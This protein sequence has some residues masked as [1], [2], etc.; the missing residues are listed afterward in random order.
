MFKNLQTPWSHGGDYDNGPI[1]HEESLTSVLPESSDRSDLTL[2]IADCAETMRKAILD[3]F[4]ANLTNEKP[5]RPSDSS[6]LP[7]GGDKA[8]IEHVKA[9]IAEQDKD[10][11]DLAARE[12]DLAGPQM[13]E[14]RTEALK[15]FDQWR[16]TVILRVGEVVNEKEL[17][18]SQAVQGTASASPRLPSRGF[19]TDR[20]YKDSA[21][22]MLKQVYPCIETPL[23]KLDQEKRAL[24]LH[25]MLL[26]VLSLEHYSAYSRTLLIYISNSLDLS[27]S[28]LAED[29][30]KVARGLL[31]SADMKA[32]EETKKAVEQGKDSRKWKVGLATV[33]GAA[34]IGLTG[35]LAA[36]LLAAGVGSVMGGLGLGA[37]ATAG[38]LGTLA[39][40]SI[41]VGGLF[42]AYGGRMTGQ[43]M[44]QYARQ[45]EDF[46][47][48]P[49]RSVH[50]PRKIE[51]E[52]TRL[53]VAVGISGWLTHKDEVVAPWRVIGPD[54]ESFALRYELEAL[55]SLGNALTTMITSAAWSFAKSEIIRRTIFASLAAALWPLGLLKVS[56]IIDNPFSV[57]KA[58]ADKA[59]LVLADALM[60]KA[61]GERPITLVGYSLGAR[62]IYSCLKRLAEQRAFGLV[63]SVFLLGAPTPSTA[64]DWRMIRAV[65]SGR[66]VNVY[67]TTDSILAFLYRSSSIQYG[68]AGLQPIEDVKGVQNFDATEFVSGHTAYRFM[69]G[70]LLAKV[71][72]EDLDME[73][74]R[75]QEVEEKTAEEK[76]EAERKEDEA[77]AGNETVSDA[78]VDELEK[79]VER[80]NQSSMLD[81][82]TEKFQVGGATAANAAQQ[83][84]NWY[85]SRP[86]EGEPETTGKRYAA[87]DHPGPAAE[88]N[89]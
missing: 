32:D 52:Y 40:S 81:W 51:I 83:A 46:A 71:G 8:W 45:V 49:I 74:V 42:G 2:L 18:E 20:D 79:T 1:D 59:G 36:P 86:T 37:T 26:L 47:F 87:V 53:R 56:R 57:A 39:S 60:N 5:S 80:K 16:N 3:T 67:S 28:F 62:V 23:V 13:Q 65:A 22:K 61:Q 17:A 54:L 75:S 7:P 84:R 58:R 50:K 33:A 11:K 30:S 10:R 69:A 24:I 64:G 76:E 68:I 55:L 38:Y 12:K 25:S 82:M 21:H 27:P 43:M 29:E 70:S 15:Q 89:A 77:A 48:V 73:A 34:V 6:K 44:D 63:E 85:N 78:K 35:G 66:V 41:L 72:F 31:A 9:D 88:K 4:D 14:L 19:E